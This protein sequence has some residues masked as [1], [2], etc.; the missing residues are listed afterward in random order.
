MVIPRHVPHIFRFVNDTV[1]A[2][3]W[4]GSFEARYYRPYR[5]LVDR[6][7]HAMRDARRHAKRTEFGERGQ[8]S[9]V[10]HAK[11]DARREA[12]RTEAGERGLGS[13][14]SH[15]RRD[16]VRDVKREAKREVKREGKRPE[17]GDGPGLK[18]AL[19]KAKGERRVKEKLDGLAQLRG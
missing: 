19:R 15:A 18:P 16:I 6:A 9:K 5:T 14:V 3:W 10:L 2:E 1:M 17:A 12:K 4:A 7:T 8:G 11:R 13:K